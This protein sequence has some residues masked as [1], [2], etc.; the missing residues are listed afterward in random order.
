MGSNGQPSEI[1]NLRISDLKK[2]KITWQRVTLLRFQSKF[3]N[4][5]SKTK[6]RKIKNQKSKINRRPQPPVASSSDTAARPDLCSTPTRAHT[7]PGPRETVAA[8]ATSQP[9]Q[10]E[11]SSSCPTVLTHLPHRPVSIPAPV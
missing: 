8:S 5:R 2:A 4:Q 9:A 1:S 10:R 7:P 6:I 11:T 3:K